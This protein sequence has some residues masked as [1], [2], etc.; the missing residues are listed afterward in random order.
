MRARCLPGNAYVLRVK[1]DPKT[2][3]FDG[4]AGAV[5]TPIPYATG[6]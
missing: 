4:P 3:A 1:G 5:E 2:L 6:Q